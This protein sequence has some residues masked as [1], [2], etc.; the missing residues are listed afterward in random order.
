M[1]LEEE[2]PNGFRLSELGQINARPIE[3][4]ALY[5]IKSTLG[6]PGLL[7]YWPLIAH[8]HQKSCI[9]IAFDCNTHPEKWKQWLCKFWGSLRFQSRLLRKS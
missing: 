7:R 2:N 3:S 8:P 6:S 1:K 5:K 4:W 9:T